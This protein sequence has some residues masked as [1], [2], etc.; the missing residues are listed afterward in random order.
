MK[1]LSIL[2]AVGILVVLSGMA[3]AEVSK[4]EKNLA[5]ESKRLNDT[6]A[7]PDGEKAVVKR[8]VTDLKATEP[9]VQALCD[10]NLSYGEV[11][12]ILSLAQVLPGG[13]TDANVQKVAALRQGPP[14]MGWGEIA[15]QLGT[16]LGKT[17]SQVRRAANNA[18]RDIKDDHARA[19]KARKQAPFEQKQQEQKNPEPPR[20]YQ[21]D[22]RLLKQGSGAQ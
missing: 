4:D 12:S 7:K 11:A 2:I 5:R 22:G 17:V 18:N 19:G 13:V 9:Q 20:S 3:L 1:R 14:V 15:R 21:G 16:K 6:V 10:R 8:L